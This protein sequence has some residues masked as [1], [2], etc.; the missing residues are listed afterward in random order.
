MHPTSPVWEINGHAVS[1]LSPLSG[2]TSLRRLMASSG[3]IADVSPLAKLTRLMELRI[4]AN[5]ISDV[6]PLANLTALRTLDVGKNAIA[7]I[8][9]LAGLTSLTYPGH[10]LQRHLR[11]F[12]H[13][14]DD[15]LED[16]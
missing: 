14:R 11:H 10:L 8:S 4:A 15:R 13:Q 12:G 16:G 9:A 5:R 2:L 3:A 1:D 7:D 6:T